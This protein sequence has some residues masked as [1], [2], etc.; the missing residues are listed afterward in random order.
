[1]NSVN[2]LEKSSAKVLPSLSVVFSFRNEEAVL[3]ELI[4]RAG[5]RFFAKSNPRER[6]LPMNLFL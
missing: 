1:M 2:E 5:G 3:P 4:Q 6:Y